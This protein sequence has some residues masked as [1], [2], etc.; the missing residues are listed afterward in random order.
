MQFI[1]PRIGPKDIYGI[2]APASAKTP[3]EDVLEVMDTY[4][5]HRKNSPQRYIAIV[6]EDQWYMKIWTLDIIFHDGKTQRKETRTTDEFKKQWEKYSEQKDVSF[7]SMLEL[8]LK[9]GNEYNSIDLYVGGKFYRVYRSKNQSW[10]ISEQNS[11][12]P[13]LLSRND[14]AGLGWPVFGDMQNEGTIIEN[15]HS[16]VN[17]LI[18]IRQL[19]QGEKMPEGRQEKVHMPS[20]YLYYFNPERDYICERIEYYSA[21]NA[22]W[23]KDKSWLDEVES[24]KLQ[25][26]TRNITEVKEYRQTGDGRWYPYKIEFKVSSYDSDI[27]ALRPYS[28]NSVK[29]VYLNTEPEFPEGIFDPNNLPK[30]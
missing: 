8:A 30:N 11:S 21:K 1:F 28:L 7:E 25:P 9:G 27:G 3:A 2:G 18:C 24:Y 17:N 19:R 6:T 4:L 22:P 14:L 26:D 12:G 20:R 15:D 10:R 5:S 29:T 23:Q 16:R 13:G